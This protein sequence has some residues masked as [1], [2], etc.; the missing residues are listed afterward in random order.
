MPY[1][2]KDSKFYW[3]SYMDSSGEYIQRSSKT[4]KLAEAKVLEQTE[5]AQAWRD[6]QLGIKPPKT[7][8]Q[9]VTKYL[10]HAR[11][12]QRSYDTTVI[13]I[14]ILRRHFA[15]QVINNL[16]A[17]DVRH[18]IDAR[19][20]D[21]ISNS[22][23]NRELSALSA[24]INHCN[25][26]Y[27]WELPNPVSG[28]R[29][30]EPEGRVRW[31]RRAEVEALCRAAREQR[32]GEL[33][34][35]FIRLAVNT[36][37]RKEE[38]LGLEWSRVDLANMLIHLDSEHNKSGKRRSIPI[39]QKALTILRSRLAHRAEHCPDAPHVFVRD[40]G[41]RV[42]TVRTGFESACKAAGIQDLH[43][44]DLRHTFAAHL[45]SEGVPLPE[46]RDLLGHSTIIMTERYAHLAPARV[47]KAVEVLDL[48]GDEESEGSLRSDYGINPVHREKEPTIRLKAIQ[49][50][51]LR[52]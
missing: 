8:E 20:K 5:R 39:N 9:V 52:E 24:A 46:V 40:T 49:G 7:F 4:T 18:Y 48:L 11:Q 13:R 10:L 21:G 26:E 30:K 32:H 36:G 33:L 38:L 44:H 23:I 47:R 29:T 37:M 34:D 3:I 1:R 43:I 28:R 50:G 2:R 35:D 14:E 42:K 31:L 19:L 17:A 22:S 41:E 16:T 51:A 45:V 12:V 27:E 15:G 25:K 6:R